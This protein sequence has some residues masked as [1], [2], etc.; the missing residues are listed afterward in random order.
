MLGWLV[1]MWLPI[2]VGKHAMA[3]HVIH[4]VLWHENA[5]SLCF[6]SLGFLVFVKY[7]L[8]STSFAGCS[9]LALRAM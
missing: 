6:G 7:F 1:R 5:S 8:V 3:Q 9:F 4:C 2:Y